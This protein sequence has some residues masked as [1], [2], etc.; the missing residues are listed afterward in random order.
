SHADH[1]SWLET[2]L[3]MPL[4]KD[5]PS[6]PSFVELTER[7]NLLVHCDGVVSHHYL[8]NCQEHSVALGTCSVG[9]KLGVPSVYYRAACDC[10]LEMA[11]KLTHV[12]W[13]KLLPNEREPA[14][15][16]LT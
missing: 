1:F 2:K 5:L 3:D 9:D 15:N 12:V 6:W 10:I 13:R 8:A 4:R 11:V 7:R 16:A 14:D